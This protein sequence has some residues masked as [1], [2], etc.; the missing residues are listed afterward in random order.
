VDSLDQSCFPELP[1]AL[2]EEMLSRSEDAGAFLYNSFKEVEKHKNEIR[3]LLQKQNILKRDSEVTYKGIPTIC[4]VDGAYA[5]EKLLAVD[6]IACA[7]VAIEG[8]DP[9][10]EKKGL[11]PPKY[12]VFVGPEKHHA[13]TE[14]LVRALM[15][16][17]E[18]ELAAKSPQ[19]MVLLD[20]SFVTPLIATK[21][22]MNRWQECENTAICQEMKKNFWEFL[23]SYTTILESSRTDKLC[24]SIPKYSTMGEIARLFNWPTQYDDKTILTMVLLPGEFTNPVPAD[25]VLQN[26]D[27]ESMQVGSDS[28]KM[29]ERIWAALGE[30]HVVYYKPFSWTPA[31]RVEVAAS[32]AKNSARL[33]LMLQGIKYQCGTPGIIEPYPLYIAD[34][35]VRSIGHALPAF[36]QIATRKMVELHKDD[37]AHI[38]F[39]MHGYKTETG[40]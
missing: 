14:T 5:V 32:I 20:G 28:Q 17:M 29:L 15:V 8:L 37:I 19:E 6:F 21:Q 26:V 11:V 31:L 7:A 10:L 35:M 24:V 3:N 39:N 23:S 2:V 1:E 12:A 38:L 18:V 30:I 27:F 13:A 34:R 22:G 25:N 33:S 9:Y 4:G 40:G 36:R 16:K